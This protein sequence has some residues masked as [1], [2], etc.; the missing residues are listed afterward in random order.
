MAFKKIPP[1]EEKEK[2]KKPAGFLYKIIN[3]EEDEPSLL[4][5]S[6]P[7]TLYELHNGNFYSPNTVFDKEFE[8]IKWLQK[9]FENYCYEQASQKPIIEYK[10][11]EKGFGV[12]QNIWN[13]LLSEVEQKLN[14]QIFDSWFKAIRFV[15]MDANYLQVA[16]TE[17]NRDWITVY[18]K[19]LIESA[20]QDL[21]LPDYQLTW[22]VSEVIPENT[23]CNYFYRLHL[24]HNFREKTGLTFEDF[25]ENFQSE[26]ADNFE[27]YYS[28]LV[29]AEEF[30]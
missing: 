5:L 2:V 11:F 4:D 22:I 13:S 24:I 19:Q 23:D 8:Q 25:C 20:L 1:E 14:K 21:N 18:Y 3:S 16:G 10:I 6:E 7:P 26:L 30:C 29:K 15:G 17:V 9:E 28:Q 12:G 27:E